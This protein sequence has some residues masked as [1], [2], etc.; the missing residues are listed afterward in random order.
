MSKLS[1]RLLLGSVMVLLLNACGS[2]DKTDD[3]GGILSDRRVEYKKQKQASLDL[4]IPPDLT[5]ST[6]KEGLSVP[7][8]GSN[9]TVYSDYVKGRGGLNR[10]ADGAVHEAVLPQVSD[11]SVQK[12]GNT[13]WLL[14]DSPA[15]SVW[16]RV[17]EFWRESG[18]LLV[19][20]N[21]SV[22]IMQTDWIE[23]RADIKG[24]ILTR[25]LRKVVDGLYSS[26]TRDQYRTRIERG[27]APGTTEV[28]LTHSGMEEKFTADSTRN[29]VD[30]DIIWTPRPS[31]PELEA[32]M[33]A[34][35][36][37]FMG[38]SE[39]KVKREVAQKEKLQPKAQIQKTGDGAIAL[40]IKEEFARAWRRTG[41]ALDQVGFVVEDRDRSK[42]IY[43][44]RYRDPMALEKKEGFFTKLFKK[45]EKD[46]NADQY[47][48]KLTELGEETEA[49][50]LDPEGERSQSETAERILTLL[51]EKM[52]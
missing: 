51:H 22:G 12:D 40:L 30:R 8:Q 9:A 5:K 32:E 1:I 35:M 49:V 50:V 10:Q 18:I 31:D 15:E 34:R 46:E 45:E 26:A 43:Y 39:A 4:E 16:P 7:G 6:I 13:R 29:D 27:Q 48:V 23:N 42:G 33:L 44:V 28:Y 37:V 47:L 21:P 11:I 2:M 3:E 41:V 19:E 38:V 24:G 20:E 36:M 25:T 52:R 17:V 14:I